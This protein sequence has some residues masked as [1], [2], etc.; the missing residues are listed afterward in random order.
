MT[1]H[2]YNGIKEI[3]ISN[4]N[5]QFYAS[6]ILRNIFEGISCEIAKLLKIKNYNLGK[7]FY[8]PAYD[9]WLLR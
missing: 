9:A 1:Y 5:L 2:L 7:F 3:E 8:N 4:S 6:L